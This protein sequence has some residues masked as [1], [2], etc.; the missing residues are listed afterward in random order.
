MLFGNCFNSISLGMKIILIKT[1]ANYAFG[2]NPQRKSV[3][4]SMAKE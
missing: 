3:T 2:F 1:L 4:N